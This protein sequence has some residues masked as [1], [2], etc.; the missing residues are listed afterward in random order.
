MSFVGALGL[1]IGDLDVVVV[2]AG[3]FS[4]I[5][6]VVAAFALAENHREGAERHL[7]SVDP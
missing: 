7:I 1:V 2:V 6:S 5:D 3:A 4:G